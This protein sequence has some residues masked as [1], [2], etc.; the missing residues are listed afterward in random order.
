MKRITLQEPLI[1]PNLRQLRDVWLGALDGRT[2]PSRRDF[3]PIK[4]PRLLPHIAMTDVFYEPLRFRYRLIGTAI[5]AM[6]GRDATG[7]WLDEDLYGDRTERFLWTFKTCVET[8][9]PV[10]VR[11][12]AQ[13]PDRDWAVVE[14]LLMPMGETGDSVEMILSGVVVVD[15]KIPHPSPDI[16]FIPDWRLGEAVP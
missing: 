8:R 1:S 14:V 5:T 10:A 6:T 4:M 11:Q 7:R 12:H 16:G 3:D 2:M 9:A 13:F 15:T